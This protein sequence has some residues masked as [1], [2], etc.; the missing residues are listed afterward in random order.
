MAD[1][2][3]ENTNFITLI[4]S[5]KSLNYWSV[6][7][8]FITLVKNASLF[9]FITDSFYHYFLDFVVLFHKTLALRRKHLTILIIVNICV[10]KLNKFTS[11]FNVKFTF[12]QKYIFD[13]NINNYNIFRLLLMLNLVRDLFIAN[14]CHPRWRQFPRNSRCEAARSA[15]SRWLTCPAFSNSIHPSPSCWPVLFSSSF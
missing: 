8:I 4:K 9:N 12:L 3:E 6:C 13:E 5:S 10:Y 7:S 14:E 11:K 15:K 2:V 1:L